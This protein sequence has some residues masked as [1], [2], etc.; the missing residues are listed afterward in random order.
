MSN[1]SDL[2]ESVSISKQQL[3]AIQ[4]LVAGAHALQKTGLLPLHEAEALSIAVRA[5]APPRS[6]SGNGSP[7]GKPDAA[8]II[9]PNAL[10][11]K[12]T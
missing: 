5:F 7:G 11:I 1:I 12:Q 4:T 6:E 10:D 3:L 8:K 2:P 9:D